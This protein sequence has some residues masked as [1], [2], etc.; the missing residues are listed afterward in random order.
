M[1]VAVEKDGSCSAGAHYYK[2]KRA[3]GNNGILFKKTRLIKHDNAR[4][5]LTSE[6][7][8]IYFHLNKET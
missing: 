6:L 2:A 7:R 5:K 1:L 3:G 4:V 8:Y